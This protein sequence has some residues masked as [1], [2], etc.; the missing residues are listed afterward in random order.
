[1]YR[2]RSGLYALVVAA[3]TLLSGRHPL[4]WIPS[5]AAW[6]SLSGAS[7]HAKRA[8]GLSSTGPKPGDMKLWSPRIGEQACCPRGH[9]PSCHEAATGRK[10]AMA[11]CEPA[12]PPRKIDTYLKW[13][14]AHLFG[15]VGCAHYTGLLRDPTWVDFFDT[16]ILGDSPSVVWQSGLEEVISRDNIHNILELGGGNPWRTQGFA[17]SVQ[18]A[19]DRGVFHQRPFRLV[20]VDIEHRPEGRQ[21]QAQ[22]AFKYVFLAAVSR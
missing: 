7:L 12:F 19:L 22:L 17:D 14:L 4:P 20:S 13:I 21:H 3:L 18:G 9:W 1:M 8:D 16:N 15:R 2:C 10:A 11:K 6:S 5:R